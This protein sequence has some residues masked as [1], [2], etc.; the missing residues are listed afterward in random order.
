MARKRRWQWWPSLSRVRKRSPP[1]L[2][3]LCPLG[4]GGGEEPFQAQQRWF[5]AGS[6]NGRQWC[7]IGGQ[8]R[9]LHASP[10]FLP[11]T[12]VSAM[13]IG[14]PW[15]T[16]CM[17]W[18]QP[19]ALVPSD[20]PSSFLLVLL[21]GLPHCPLVGDSVLFHHLLWNQSPAPNSLPVTA[22]GSLGISRWALTDEEHGCGS[23]HLSWFLKG[24]KTFAK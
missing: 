14:A 22:E 3:F 17:G 9:Q 1:P 18:S 16:A 6:A 10:L 24:D 8:Q 11:S 19:L 5:L 7:Q 12:W 21:S 2:L 15:G 20:C 4:L 23:W 13:T